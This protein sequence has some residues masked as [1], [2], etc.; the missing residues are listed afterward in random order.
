MRRGD[1][2]NNVLSGDKSENGRGRNES[3]KTVR[4]TSGKE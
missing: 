3:R 4:G 1:R 2:E